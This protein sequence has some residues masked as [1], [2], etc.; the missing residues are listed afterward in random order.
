[1]T[2]PICTELKVMFAEM[3][4]LLGIHGIFSLKFLILSH[5][6]KSGDGRREMV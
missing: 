6:K 4:V 2:L 1:M 3:F 5:R